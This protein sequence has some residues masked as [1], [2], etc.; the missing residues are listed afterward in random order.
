[1][2]TELRTGSQTEQGEMQRAL[3]NAR[4]F[5]GVAPLT[6]AVQWPVGVAC[7]VQGK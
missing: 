4:V 2:T 7:S 1:M 5:G 3:L 6:F